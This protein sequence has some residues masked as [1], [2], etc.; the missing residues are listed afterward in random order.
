MENQTSTI[1]SSTKVE[2]DNVNPWVIV[3]QP[4]Q[5]LG[6][7]SGLYVF[8]NPSIKKW[9]A[10]GKSL[11][12]DNKVDLVCEG[13]TKLVNEFNFT[14]FKVTPNDPTQAVFLT[15]TLK[16]NEFEGYNCKVDTYRRESFEFGA[17]P[18]LTPT[19]SKSQSDLESTD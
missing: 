8:Y 13:T 3:G 18:S 1:E 12:F 5:F 6:S 17:V 11:A 9:I 14:F 16:S 2:S 15:P 19:Q 10:N 7:E 4:S